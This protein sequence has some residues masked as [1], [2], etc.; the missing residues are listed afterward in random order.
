M[1][2][3]IIKLSK[4]IA[5]TIKVARLSIVP[6]LNLLSCKTSFRTLKRLFEPCLK[7][8]QHLHRKVLMLGAVPTA[9]FLTSYRDCTHRQKSV[10]GF[11]RR[12]EKFKDLA[13]CH[14]APLA[15]KLFLQKR[16]LGCLCS[17]KPS[18]NTPK[19]FFPPPALLL[20]QGRAGVRM[21]GMARLSPQL[22]CEGRARLRHPYFY[23]RFVSSYN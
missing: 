18:T 7:I 10:K 8:I 16:G 17:A 11:Q 12:I 2:A 3:V 9:F 19:S 13:N 15:G 1:I 22:H 14:L 6:G 21:F 23:T 20:L 4:M 5:A